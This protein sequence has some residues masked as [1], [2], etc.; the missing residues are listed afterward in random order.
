MQTSQYGYKIPETGD[1][2]SGSSGWMQAIEDNFE[3]LDQH[4]HDGTDSKA[5][6]ASS[7]SKYTSTIAS[8]GYTNDGGGNYSKTITVPAA[9]TEVNNY[10]IQ[11][12]ITASGNRIYP[13][14]ERL[15]A[16]TYTL[17]V[18]QEVAITAVYV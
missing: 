6:P 18:N 2:A 11:F 7:I 3:R 13:T 10:L 8:T 17:R 16:T 1:L 4:D 9:V 14:V 15:T 12:Y 5:L